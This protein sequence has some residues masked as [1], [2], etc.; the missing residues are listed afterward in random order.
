[1]K[2]R[3]MTIKDLDSKGKAG[4]I[5]GGAV[6]QDLGSACGKTCKKDGYL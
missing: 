1:M 5:K 2:L 4:Q 6:P 3:R